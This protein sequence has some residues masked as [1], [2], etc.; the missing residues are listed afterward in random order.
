[1]ADTAYVI[2]ADALDIRVLTRKIT[3]F[4]A[5]GTF[6]S[7]E[8]VTPLATTIGGRNRSVTFQ[9]NGD[10][11]HRVTL[12]LMQHHPDDTYLMGAIKSQQSLSTVL[13]FSFKYL[14]TSY[15]SQACVIETMPTRD[16]AAD[17]VPNVSYVLTGPFP[18]SFIGAFRQPA[19]ATDAQI[20]SFIPA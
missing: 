1:M 11:L 2:P 16:Y 7:I 5:T 8:K 12:T 13:T 10:V 18:I 4:P 14:G 19:V 9:L 17:G 3:D 15:G 20:Q 6:M